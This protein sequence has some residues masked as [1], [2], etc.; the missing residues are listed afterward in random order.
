MN[1]DL[2]KSPPRAKLHLRL[3]VEADAIQWLAVIGNI[4][5]G[6]RHP[7]NDGPSAELAVQF[8]DN[9]ADLLVGAGVLTLAQRA[10]MTHQR[11]ST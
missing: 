5:L 2:M 9:V 10:F 7:Q 3:S 1:E 6:L 4:E 11:N 8:V